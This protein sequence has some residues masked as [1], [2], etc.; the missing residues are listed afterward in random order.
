[1]Y[2]AIETV[3]AFDKP[4]HENNRACTAGNERPTLSGLTKDDVTASG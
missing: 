4:H 1:M 2:L 3:E